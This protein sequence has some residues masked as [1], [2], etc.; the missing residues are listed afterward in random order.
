ML[1]EQRKQPGG[2]PVDG[3]RHPRARRQ[4]AARARSR[5]RARS[6]T[7]MNVALEKQGKI[8]GDYLTRSRRGGEGCSRS[9]RGGREGADV[10]VERSRGA[11]VAAGERS[12][13][14]RRR[15]QARRR[16][17]W[18][19]K[20]ATSRRCS[21]SSPTSTPSS[22]SSS[23][24]PSASRPSR[25]VSSIA[26]GEASD[27]VIAINEADRPIVGTAAPVPGAPLHQSAGRSP[28]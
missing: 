5:R 24:A 18:T 4:A 10:A 1:D 17:S 3:G 9:T 8:V 6:S 13:D 15:R 19:P 12:S 22:N 20:T 2:D 21:R 25:R 7:Q 16:A 11:Q 28:R 23:R 27:G 14:P 26:H